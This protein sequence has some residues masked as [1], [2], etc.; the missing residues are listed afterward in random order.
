M[1][2]AGT[3]SCDSASYVTSS[4]TPAIAVAV[5]LD[6]RRVTRVQPDGVCD[7]RRCERVAVDAELEPRDGIPERHTP[8]I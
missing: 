4:P 8:S 5:E 6:D 2:S 3:P 1:S 7:S